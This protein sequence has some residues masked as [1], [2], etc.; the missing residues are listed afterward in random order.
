[1]Y[2]FQCQEAAKNEACT[3]KG[4]CGKPKETA[5]LQDLLIFVSKG[6]AVY[7]EKLRQA[8]GVDE[9]AAR[10]VRKALFVTV[11]NVAWDDA[12]IIDWVKE[13]LE[14]RAAV[15]EKIGSDDL[16]TLPE[17][18]TWTPRN[19]EE[20]LAQASSDEVRITSTENE[21][22]RSLRELLVI[23]CKGIAAYADHAAVLGYRQ[24]EIDGFL[25]EECPLNL[26]C[27]VVHRVDFPGTHCWFVG[28]IE[29]VHVD[30]GYVRDQ[31]LM[32]WSGEY[33]GVG[34]FLESAW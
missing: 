32:F 28:E 15:R 6:V 21:D 25:I 9:D 26:E 20:I 3:V 13:G 17:C 24:D 22:V 19:D 1:M 4:V 18:A 5:D 7:G 33:R 8:G 12:E 23:G 14:V 30:Q 10:F 27:R 11:T 16:G 34:R 31:A 2:C 29:A